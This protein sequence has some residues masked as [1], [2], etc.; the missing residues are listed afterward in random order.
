MR[1]LATLPRRLCNEPWSGMIVLPENGCKLDANFE[2]RLEP[3]SGPL[4]QTACIPTRLILHRESELEGYREAANML[5]RFYPSDGCSETI[6][7]NAARRLFTNRKVYRLQCE[8]DGATSRD[9]LVL[10]GDKKDDSYRMMGAYIRGVGQV[11][12]E[13]NSD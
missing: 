4:T 12:V 1:A 7:R 9:T 3:S 6:M 2:A 10:F 8:P 11:E 13:K 5:V